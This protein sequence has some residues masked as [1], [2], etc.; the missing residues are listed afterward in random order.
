[1]SAYRERG[2]ISPASESAPVTAARQVGRTYAAHATTQV[3]LAGLEQWTPG[4]AALWTRANH[5]G[6]EVTLLEGPAVVAGLVA[7]TLLDGGPSRRTRAACATA[8]AAIGAMGAYDDLAGATATK[9]LKGH[10]RALARG[11]VTSGALKIAVIGGAGLL[12]AAAV[13][14]DVE[15]SVLHPGTLL[16]GALVAGAANLVNLLDLRPGRALKASLLGAAL[17]F[18]TSTGGPL[19]APV[20][21]SALAAAPDDLAATAMLGDCGS[22]ALGAAI[23]L[24]VVAAAGAR[25]RMLTV[26]SLVAL[27]LASE[28]VSYSEVIAATPWLRR[29]DEWG[30][31]G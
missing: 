12:G 5:A 18:V 20:V 7:G 21:G 1:M 27:T 26:A 24:S 16:D 9:G 31:V 2:P 11:D 3:V 29:L 22:N 30:R 23:G 13:R 14:A 28:K 4:G 19:A 17:P 8:L 25:V 10:L 15:R 6:R